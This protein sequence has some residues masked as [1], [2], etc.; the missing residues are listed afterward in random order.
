LSP[1]LGRAV[2][3]AYVG[4]EQARAGTELAVVIRGRECPARVVP[5]PFY[6]RS[7]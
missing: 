2:A 5:T 7:R 4:R 1:T 3:L 6:R